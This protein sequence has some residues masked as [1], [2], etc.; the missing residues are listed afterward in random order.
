MRIWDLSP[1]Y[2]NRQSLLG[3]HREL[4]GIYSILTTGK[5]GYARH[6]ETLRW[7]DAL[8]GLVCRHQQLM[9]EMKLRGFTDRTPL[10]AWA[11]APAWPSSFVTEPGRQ[12]LLLRAKYVHREKG[13][14]PLPRNCEQLWAQHK[15]SVMARSLEE[16]RRCGRWANRRRSSA[17]FAGFAKDLVLI[18]RLRPDP[19]GLANAVEHLW[20]YVRSAATAEDVA[21]AKR[22]PRE[23]FARIQKIAM[24]RRERYLMSS[25]ALSDFAI[26]L[27]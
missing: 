14:I 11:S 16:Y 13:R 12:I 23:M 15:Y 27:V 18:L 6:P 24:L 19:G 8:D 7:V 25:T 20:G 3:E 2:L 22:D 21:A 5:R 17:E 1:G 26:F 9:A 10:A 4:H